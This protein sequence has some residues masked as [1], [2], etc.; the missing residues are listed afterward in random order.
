MI[1]P[2]Q[3]VPMSPSS[4]EAFPAVHKALNS[5]AQYKDIFGTDN[6]YLELQDNKIERQD[7][8]VRA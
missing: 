5:A 1:P 7:E 3:D 6:F 2:L 4:P 8:F